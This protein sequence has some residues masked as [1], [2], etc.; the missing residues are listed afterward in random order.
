MER[1]TKSMLLVGAL[2][3][4]ITT[5]ILQ[6]LPLLSAEEE[7]EQGENE[8]MTVE[9]LGIQEATVHASNTLKANVNMK[10]IGHYNSKYWWANIDGTAVTIRSCPDNDFN[11]ADTVERTLTF[12]ETPV[13]VQNVMLRQWGQV[14]AAVGIITIDAGGG[15]FRLKHYNT[16]TLNGGSS[17]TDA[18]L[19]GGVQTSAANAVSKV[20][21][22]INISAGSQI[23]TVTSEAFGPTP[24]WTPRW[25][26]L[27][28]GS[29]T[30]PGTATSPNPDEFYGGYL[31][32]SNWHFLGITGGQFEEWYWPVGMS[33][34]TSVGILTALT[35]PS[36]F[37]ANNQLFWKQGASRYVIDSDHFYQEDPNANDWQTETATATSTNGA[38]WNH[39]PNDDYI[40]DYVAW[41]DLMWRIFRNGGVARF[42]SIS[43]NAF[44]GY[45]RFITTGTTIYE[46]AILSTKDGAFIELQEAKI[47]TNYPNG[48]RA[49]LT[50]T[51]GVDNW[52][53]DDYAVLYRD[54]VQIFEGFAEEDDNLFGILMV[55]LKSGAVD[56]L[57]EP[58]DEVYASGQKA[59]T[60][61]KDLLDKY[62][63]FIKYDQSGTTIDTTDS[64]ISSEIRFTNISLKKA[65]RRLDE[66]ANRISYIAPDQELF[67]DDGTNDTG[68]N[69]IE[70]TD[71]P[72]EV[73]PRK[74][75]YKVKRAVVL[76]KY[77][78]G[79]RVKKTA[80]GSSLGKGTIIKNHP[81]I[82]D[83]TVLQGFA[84]DIVA[85]RDVNLFIIQFKIEGKGLVQYGKRIDLYIDQSHFTYGTPVTGDAVYT[86]GC[87]YEAVN[88]I[89]TP[90]VY[91]HL[92]YPDV[93][94]D[95][96]SPENNEQLIGNI[97]K[98]T[99]EA[100]LMGEANAD[101]IPMGFRGGQ[102]AGQAS[103]DLNGSIISGIGGSSDNLVW[104][105]VGIPYQRGVK[106]LY[107]KGV[108]F[109]L[110]DADA[111]DR[112]DIVRLLILKG[113]VLTTNINDNNGGGGWTT[114]DKHIWSFTKEDASLANTVIV[115]LDCTFTTTGDLD[116]GGVDVLCYYGT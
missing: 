92:Y 17:W 66:I 41:D 47:I 21:D 59:S 90:I 11:V 99:S 68:V 9:F 112:V 54:G 14:I 77:V 12:A 88:G 97:E 91:S 106:K 102:A 4:I 80:V 62:A 65:I 95:R 18:T 108:R 81:T 35:V 45:D 61:L 82:S 71:D 43:V 24:V 114:I 94:V 75:T 48:P 85:K 79:V 28:T 96:A 67:W 7:N 98:D 101:W 37:D 60:I 31:V 56:D 23:W 57:A 36:T 55:P 78:D 44:V 34:S 109:N 105:L 83:G 29:G 104:E 25:H 103:Y 111:D 3:V 10:N 1:K 100:L 70:P 113:A 15:N 49:L 84:D 13:A 86:M 2:V 22:I 116:I 72:Y 16:Y 8:N 38:V 110:F 26:N 73:N 51:T 33:S 76:G 74:K 46:E 6:S 20:I 50:D 87:T 64:T 52:D 89:T 115:R 42:S 39:D 40:L 27:R 93:V 53:F 32:G 63:L 69:V 19:L 58:V 30:V 107:I 5:S